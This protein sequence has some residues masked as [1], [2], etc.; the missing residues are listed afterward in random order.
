MT[1]T[2]HELFQIYNVSVCT[3][4]VRFKLFS[5]RDGD[6]YTSPIMI[7]ITVEMTIPIMITMFLE[8][9][10]TIT[11]ISAAVIGYNRL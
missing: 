8:I 2:K 3:Q 10:I 9:M 7:M 4:L 5:F 1:G 6:D 11:T